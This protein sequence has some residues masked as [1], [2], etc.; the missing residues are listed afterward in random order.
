MP[1]WSRIVDRKQEAV[2]IAKAVLEART[3]FIAGRLHRA[4]HMRAGNG[5]CA[6]CVAEAKRTDLV[7]C[8]T[9]S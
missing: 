8:Q 2:R 3:D 9:G 7:G 5:R 4:D 6:F 1:F